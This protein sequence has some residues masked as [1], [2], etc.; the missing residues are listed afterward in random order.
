MRKDNLYRAIFVILATV[1]IVMSVLLV[2][3]SNRDNI[4]NDYSDIDSM[5][6]VAENNTVWY[7]KI[8]RIGGDNLLPVVEDNGVFYYVSE[9]G[10][11]KYDSS[12]NANTLL[13]S[14]S[15][16]G[17]Y[18]KDGLV[19]YHTTDEILQYDTDT[20]N[21]SCVWSLDETH[22]KSEL[23]SD[24]EICD[25]MFHGNYIYIWNTGISCYR[26]NLTTKEAENFLDDVSNCVF[27][28]THCYYIDH[29]EKTF[30]LYEK[31][32]KTL[33]T[34]LIVG[35]GV[36]KPQNTAISHVYILDGE[37]YYH[38]RVSEAIYKYNPNGEDEKIVANNM[39]SPELL[40][41]QSNGYL[42][43]A[44]DENGKYNIYRIDEAGDSQLLLTENSNAHNGDHIVTDS[45]I[46]CVPY[47]D[48][49]DKVSVKFVQSIG[50]QRAL[51]AVSNYIKDGNV[52]RGTG[53]T[54]KISGVDYY[55]ISEAE[56]SPEKQTVVRWYAV[57]PKTFSVGEWNVAFDTVS[58]S[59]LYDKL[60]ENIDKAYKAEQEKPE[61]STTGGMV[62]LADRYSLKWQQ[63]A[64]EYYAKL[65]EYRFK[66]E[67]PEMGCTTEQLH[68]VIYDMKDSWKTYYDQ[69]IANYQIVLNLI[70]AGGTIRQP[71][72][73][74]YK[75]EMNM[76][77]ALK[78]VSIY[79]SLPK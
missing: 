38:E 54:Q 51:K 23:Y 2:K 45:A 36:Y 55:L 50:Y 28:D 21:I 71:L 76:E 27:S 19:Y 17:L 74:N 49:E 4:N 1:V 7:E 68:K 20:N 18:Y 46:F 73:A 14:G 77:W 26:V 37:L 15:Y 65:M 9:A 69:E 31:D 13:T 42:C 75:Y 44:N 62:E 72:L 70:Y 57:H 16:S 79:D 35:E 29:A 66:E 24:D 33:E 34:K 48:S 60:I 56:D 10:L 32:L 11:Y 64:E 52:L 25:F 5:S 59:G 6:D 53:Y 12:K 39:Y 47:Y 78:L 40:H 67:Y 22:I 41:W 3:P 58:F 61:Y 63:V 43:Y 30:S 8:K